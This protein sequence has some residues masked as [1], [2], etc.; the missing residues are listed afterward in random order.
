MIIWDEGTVDVSN[1]SDRHVA[2]ELHGHKLGGRF[3]LTRTGDRRWILVKAADDHARPGT[4]IV[5][6]QPTSVRS[7]LTVDEMAALRSG[8]GSG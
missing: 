8:G 1:E 3:A 6:D 7:G 5:S 4:D 2:F